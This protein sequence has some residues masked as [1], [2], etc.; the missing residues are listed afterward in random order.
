MRLRKEIEVCGLFRFHSLLELR[1]SDL[2]LPK[3]LFPD[4]VL[5]FS[6]QIVV[7]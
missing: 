7:G 5:V 1:D 2:N 6:A 4:T 3:M